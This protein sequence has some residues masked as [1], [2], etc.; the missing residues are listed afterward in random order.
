MQVAVPKEH[1]AYSGIEVSWS[2]K[3]KGLAN[4]RS[5]K[6]EEKSIRAVFETNAQRGNIINDFGKETIDK[7]NSSV[8]S[9]VPKLERNGSMS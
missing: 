4:K 7:K 2:C 1:T 5:Q 3:D 9:F 8:K 6:Y